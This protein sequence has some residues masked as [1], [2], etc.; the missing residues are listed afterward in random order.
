VIQELLNALHSLNLIQSNLYT[1]N[2]CHV[3][4]HW[5]GSSLF[6]L[7]Q[8]VKTPNLRDN[9]CKYYRFT[10]GISSDYKLAI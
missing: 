2:I 10:H 5:L 4:M 6:Y 7:N 8:T 9:K 1:Y 3:D